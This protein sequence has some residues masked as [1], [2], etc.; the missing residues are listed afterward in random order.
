MAAIAGI[1][2]CQLE[3]GILSVGVLIFFLGTGTLHFHLQ[4]SGI[5]LIKWPPAGTDS[6][7]R[8]FSILLPCFEGDFYW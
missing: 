7:E 1:S 6:Q 3:E 4:T 5:S 2:C 8:V